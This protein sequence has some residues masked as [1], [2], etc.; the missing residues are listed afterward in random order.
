MYNTVAVTCGRCF[1]SVAKLRGLL[2]DEPGTDTFGAGVDFAGSPVQDR[3]YFLEVGVKPAFGYIMGVADIVADHRLF[4]AY[5]T[6]SGHCFR[7]LSCT[8]FFA[9]PI[10]NKL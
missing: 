8:V 7:F 3:P 9:I 10:K 2:H 1:L 6:L 5:F 4:P